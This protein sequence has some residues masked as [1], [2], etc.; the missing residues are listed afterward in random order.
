VAGIMPLI[1]L[2]GRKIQVELI[3][4]LILSFLVSSILYV[5]GLYKINNL[6]IYNLF[7]IGSV[8]FLSIYYFNTLF[9]RFF[10][11]LVVISSGLCCLLFFMELSKTD[12]IVITVK[13]ENILFI[14][15]S[16]LFYIDFLK[17]DKHSIKS[18][19]SLI[20]VNSSIFIYNFS[21]FILIYYISIFMKENIWF[22][23]NFIEGS[24][25]LL[26]AY[27]FWKIPIT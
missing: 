23:H 22:V 8:I 15:W 12:D 25:K 18:N 6:L 13:V 4:F 27:A 5:T 16:F 20:I 19:K 24:S 21:S 1:F 14:C 7:V 10:K 17:N 3:S 26:I 11:Y 9:N 2:K